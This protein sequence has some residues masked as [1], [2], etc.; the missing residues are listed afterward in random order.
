MAQKQSIPRGPFRDLVCRFVSFPE[1]DTA[2]H[3]IP[4]HEAGSARTGNPGCG[5]DVVALWVR[6]VDTGPLEHRLL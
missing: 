2:P 6:K 4:S 1:V 5:R 3:R